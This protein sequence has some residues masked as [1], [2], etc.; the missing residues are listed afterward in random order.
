MIE[1]LFD[2][3]KDTKI[4][5]HFCDAVTFDYSKLSYDMVFTS[6]PYYNIEIYSGSIS[7]SK[8]EWIEDFYN[9]LFM[10]VWKY[11]LVDG[12]MCIN[13][14][15]VIYNSVFIKMFGIAQIIIPMSL[16]L[17]PKYA[18]KEYIY[19]WKKCT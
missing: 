12:W 17:R 14:S 16:K 7:K 5:T 19:C 13:V 11:L 10:S 8:K 6:P 3:S 18:I 9:P 15:T 1:T 2:I 4:E